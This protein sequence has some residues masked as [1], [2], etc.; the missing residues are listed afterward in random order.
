MDMIAENDM[1]A[2]VFNALAF[3]SRLGYVVDGLQRFFLLIDY[4][5]VFDDRGKR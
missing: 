4:L 2:S 5:Y 3:E 1:N